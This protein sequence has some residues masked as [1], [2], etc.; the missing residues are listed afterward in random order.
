MRKTSIAKRLPTISLLALIMSGLAVAADN[1]FAGTWKI[2]D[3]KSSW[4]DGRFPKNMSLTIDLNFNGNEIKYHS[5][6]D[7]AKGKPPAVI[8]YVA[9]MDG[10]SYPLPNSARFNQVSIRRLSD[11][12]MEILELK[13]GDV[14]VGAIW[15]VLPG[16]KRLVRRGIGKSPEG[17]SH[18]YEEFFARQ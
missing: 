17:K 4:S 8:D 7:T 14:I 16:G 9:T 11:D 18:A 6:N 13:D 1:P 5:V 10:K 3:S 12:Q 2:D 15:E